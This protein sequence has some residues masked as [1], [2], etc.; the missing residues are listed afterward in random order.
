MITCQSARPSRSNGPGWGWPST[1][2]V[3]GSVDDAKDSRSL[4]L[5]YT[6]NGA[7]SSLMK[8][9]RTGGNGPYHPWQKNAR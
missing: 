5:P 8:R 9:P 4:P 7:C 6:Q 1:V 2:N 3:R